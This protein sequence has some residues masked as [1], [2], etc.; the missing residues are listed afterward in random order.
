LDQTKLSRPG[1]DLRL[2]AAPFRFVSRVVRA[3]IFLAVF[4]LVVLG[5]CLH[6]AMVG[7]PVMDDDMWFLTKVL[8]CVLAPFVLALVAGIF[9]KGSLASAWANEFLVLILSFVAVAGLLRSRVVTFNDGDHAPAIWTNPEYDY[10]DVYGGGSA[11][12]IGRMENGKFELSSG[13]IRHLRGDCRKIADAKYRASCLKS[14]DCMKN[15]ATSD[16]WKAQNCRR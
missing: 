12:R 1:G 15:S 3:A 10:S 14:V 9:S 2:L 6:A 8:F 4:P 7:G 16:D 5:L 11:F 13:E